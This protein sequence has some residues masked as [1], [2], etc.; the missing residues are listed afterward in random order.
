L[1]ANSE[2]SYVSRCY[3]VT[4]G[5]EKNDYLLV[6]EYA[7]NGDLHDNLSKNFKEITWEDKIKSLVQ[8]SGG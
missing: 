4:K 2:I 7:K 8:I 5:S 3:G 1:K 6:F